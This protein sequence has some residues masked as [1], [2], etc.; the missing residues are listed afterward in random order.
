M[1]FEPEERI[2]EDTDLWYRVAAHYPLLLIKKETAVY[3]RENSTATLKGSNN[4]NWMFARRESELVKDIS[5]PP[6]KRKH[7]RLLI[8][9]WRCTCCRELLH[10]GEVNGAEQ[11]LKYV[12][13][14]AQIR[15]IYCWLLCVKSRI[16][17]VS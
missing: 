17:G 2:G 4:L 6:R 10:K 14:P 12:T 3:H 8:D 9:R 15:V 16:L 13:Y 11:Y 5:I 7:I 1:R